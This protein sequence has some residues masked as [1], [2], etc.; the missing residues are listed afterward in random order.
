MDLNKVAAAYA[1]GSLPMIPVQLM[2]AIKPE[3]LTRSRVLVDKHD[4]RRFHRYDSNRKQMIRCE[5]S[6]VIRMSNESASMRQV[7]SILKYNTQSIMGKLIRA[8]L[9]LT[10]WDSATVC[11]MLPSSLAV[12]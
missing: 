3:F 5:T 1:T 11:I 4:Q 12:V 10:C 2:E 7:V 6:N 9:I 8:A